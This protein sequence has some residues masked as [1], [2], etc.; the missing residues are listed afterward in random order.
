MASGWA[1]DGE[2]VKEARLPELSVST[3][4]VCPDSSVYE[5]ARIFVR[6][7]VAEIKPLSNWAHVS[8]YTRFIRA[9][10][11]SRLGAV[12]TCLKEARLPDFFGSITHVRPWPSVARNP[13]MVVRAVSEEISLLSNASHVSM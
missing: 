2:D 12:S 4:H 8:W 13:K 3:R 5:M 10:S 6:A 11:S 7:C 1:T 9:N